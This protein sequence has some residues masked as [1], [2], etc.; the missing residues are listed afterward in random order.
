MS[1]SEGSS[2]ESVSSYHDTRVEMVERV[3]MGGC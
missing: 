3:R 1:A 2:P